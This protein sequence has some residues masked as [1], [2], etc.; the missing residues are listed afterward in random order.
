MAGGL[1]SVRP[2]GGFWKPCLGGKPVV[3]VVSVCAWE[4]F[5]ACRE[6]EV[7]DR[8]VRLYWGSAGSGEGEKAARA[9][10]L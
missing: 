2:C 9:G 5:C 7:V 6:W 8:R 3:G 10:A 4:E 1:Q